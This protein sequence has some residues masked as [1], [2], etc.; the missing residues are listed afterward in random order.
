MLRIKQI[1]IKN[2]RSIVDLD[3]NVDKMNIFVGLNDAGKSNILKA[4]I[5]FLIMRQNLVVHLILK[6]IIRSMRL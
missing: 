3:I 5:C 4:L 2:F 1:R 6:L